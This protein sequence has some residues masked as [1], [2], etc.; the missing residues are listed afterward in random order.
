MIGVILTAFNILLLLLIWQVFLKKTILD[1]HRDQLFDLRCKLRQAFADSNAL[2][3]K[4][5]METRKLLNAQI[6]LTEN[7]S[8]LQYFLWKRFTN[9]EALKNKIANNQMNF[10]AENSELQKLVNDIRSDASIVCSS[11]MI[12]SSLTLTIIVFITAFVMGI[13]WVFRNIFHNFRSTFKVALNENAYLRLWK[14]AVS[15]THINQ[16]MIEDASKLLLRKA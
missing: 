1:A 14:D 2:N 5:Y 11:Y 7:L 6:A 8:I 13:G 9:S 4:S 15:R 12:L 10:R 3:S 16:D